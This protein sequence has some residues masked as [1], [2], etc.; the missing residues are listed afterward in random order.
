MPITEAKPLMLVV[1]GAVLDRDGRVLIAQRP[2]GK[3]HA[4]LWE[5][6]GGK[7]EDGETPEQALTRELREE[8][9]IEPCDHCLQPFSFASFDYPD[10]HLLMPL[11]LCREWDGIARPQ[12]GQAI[13]WVWPSKLNDVNWVPADVDLAAELSHRLKDGTRYVD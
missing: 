9:L 5:F 6:P 10:M 1:A 12:D 8:L 13:K 2:E 4:G 7:V 3:S 11:F